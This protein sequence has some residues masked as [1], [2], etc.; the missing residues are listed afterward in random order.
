MGY[1]GMAWGRIC[2]PDPAVLPACVDLCP[3]L[4]PHLPCCHYLCELAD[5]VRAFLDSYKDMLP[6]TLFALCC[7]YCNHNLVASATVMPHGALRS[8]LRHR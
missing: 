5:A 6:S 3:V 7:A 2:L 1:M 4:P 8:R